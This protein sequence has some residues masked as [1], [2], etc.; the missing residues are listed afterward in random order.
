[1]I[2]KHPDQIVDDPKLISDNSQLILMRTRDYHP[3]KRKELKIW[4]DAFMLKKRIKKSFEL[5][6]IEAEDALRQFQ[7]NVPIKPKALVESILKTDFAKKNAVE[8]FH[9][10]SE[11]L[12]CNPE[13]FFE[14]KKE[15]SPSTLPSTLYTKSNGKNISKPVQHARLLAFRNI[16][17]NDI[18][19][20][21]PDM[22][23]FCTHTLHCKNYEDLGET[24]RI[25]CL[26]KGFNIIFPR[27]DKYETIL[28]WCECYGDRK[29]VQSTKRTGCDFKLQYERTPD[30]KGYFLYKYQA[31]H[32]H[33]I[34]ERNMYLGDYAF[35]KMNIISKE[36][37]KVAQDPAN[38][39]KIEELKKES[40]DPRENYDYD[41][42]YEDFINGIKPVEDMRVLRSFNRCVYNRKHIRIDA[43]CKSRAFQEF[44]DGDIQD[45]EKDGIDSNQSM[46]GVYTN[47]KTYPFYPDS[48]NRHQRILHCAQEFELELLAKNYKR[49]LTETILDL[50]EDSFEKYKIAQLSKKK[51]KIE[52]KLKELPNENLDNLETREKYL[53]LNQIS[54]NISPYRIFEVTSEWNDNQDGS[55]CEFLKDTMTQ[56]KI[57]D[58]FYV[59][60]R[61]VNRRKT[62]KRRPFCRSR[63]KRACNR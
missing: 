43:A 11:I 38:A 59:P 34:D 31:C 35:Q 32:N 28:Y 54:H 53:K 17:V 47:V 2:V 8:S 36:F 40:V 24:V 58:D 13:L 30:R 46:A 12:Q 61:V 10:N 63:G 6:M 56:Y 29:G 14:Y 4:L 44:E 60:K 57:E 18:E 55:P 16:Y 62:K 52:R 26:M 33:P 42:E 23:D 25:L 45:I 1:M 41:Q 20:L 9:K 21:T 48:D 39:K 15:K 5:K 51:D 22:E 27:G 49:D 7:Q 50:E 19:I 37:R 3:Y